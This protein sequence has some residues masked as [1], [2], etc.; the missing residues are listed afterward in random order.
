MAYYF[1]TA[2]KDASI[3]LQQPNQNAGIDEILE[4]SKVYYGTIKDVS[5]TIIK[6]ETGFLSES[7]SRGDMQIEDAKLILKETQSEEIP[8]EYTL[9]AYPI[10]GSWEM[11]IGTRFDNISTAGVTWNYREGDSQLIWMSGA[12]QPNTDANPNSGVGGVWYTVSSSFQSFNYQSSDI[13]MDVIDMIR[14]WVSGSILNDGLILKYD[15][16]I[17]N[18]SQNYGIIKFFSKETNTIYQPKIRIGWDDQLFDTGSLQPV[19]TGGIVIGITNFKKQYRVGTTPIIRIFG[20]EQYP[21]KTFTDTFVY[22]TVKYLPKNTYY[23]VKDFAS[24]EII[25]PFSEY[26]KVSCDS[27]GNYIK[28]NLSNWEYDRVY[29]IEFKVDFGNYVEYFDGE[30]TFDVIKN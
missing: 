5:R 7:V 18:N 9:Y 10:S 28:I 29:K 15:N 22:T 23:Q 4:I 30:Y 13:E 17:E 1:I 6:F 26:T 12:L 20:R 25:V 24:D 16:D 27:V 11:G 21:L 3:Y 8:L 19:P 14:N 2:S